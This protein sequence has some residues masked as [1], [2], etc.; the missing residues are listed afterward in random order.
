M[1][2]DETYGALPAMLHEKGVACD[3]NTRR[4]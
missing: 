2:K 1:A 4:P 3:T